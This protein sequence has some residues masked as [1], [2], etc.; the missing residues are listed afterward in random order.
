MRLL[1]FATVVVVALASYSQHNFAEIHSAGE[2]TFVNYNVGLL[3][4]MSSI[5]DQN[6]CMR[7]ELTHL[8]TSCSQLTD[9]TRPEVYFIAP[10]SSRFN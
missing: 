3:A 7:H 4:E 6:D 8:H 10:F 2:R 5:A 1:I 9:Q